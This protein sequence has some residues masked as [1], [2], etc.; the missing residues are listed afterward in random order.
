[1]YTHKQYGLAFMV[2]NLDGQILFATVVTA[3]G[4]SVDFNLLEEGLESTVPLWFGQI[5]SLPS[6]ISRGG[7]ERR[8]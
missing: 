7:R 6:D 4:I 2:S 8:R 1:M 5:P 3:N